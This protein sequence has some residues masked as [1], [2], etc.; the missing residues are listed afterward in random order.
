MGHLVITKNDYIRMPNLY[1]FSFAILQNVIQKR[2]DTCQMQYT[3]IANTTPRVF[4]LPLLLF[5]CT[6]KL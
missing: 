2:P 4:K 1:R 3:D 6:H 5:V